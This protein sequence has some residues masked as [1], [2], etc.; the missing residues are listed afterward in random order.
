MLP[1][2]EVNE[3]GRVGRV[4]LQLLCD[5]QR[6]GGGGHFR[7]LG[8]VVEK[9]HDVGAQ[10]RF[11]QHAAGIF[12]N[13][14]VGPHL[15]QVHAAGSTGDFHPGEA[16][17]DNYPRGTPVVAGSPGAGDKGTGWGNNQVTGKH[18]D[19]AVGGVH[20]RGA[21]MAPKERGCHSV[22]QC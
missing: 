22:G 7:G 2:G 6:R 12:A 3:R 17:G 1:L 4:R 18:G 15:P 5:G 9:L 16:N 21:T 11:P 19:N 13:H 14:A 20:D 10:F 8:P